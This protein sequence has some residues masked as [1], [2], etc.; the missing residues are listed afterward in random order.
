MAVLL[1]MKLTDKLM[2]IEILGR[3]VA[4]GGLDV[5]GD[6]FHEVGRV[7]VLDV[8]HLLVDLLGGQ[9]TTEHGG[10]G[11]VAAVAGVGGTHHV[12]GVE[13]LLRQ[14]GHS[15]STVLLRTTRSQGGKANHVEV[16][17][18]EGDQ[19]DGELAQIGVELTGEAEGASDTAHD[20]RHE[21][22]EISECGGGELQSAEADVVRAK[23]RRQNAC[24]RNGSVENLRRSRR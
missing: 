17:T 19:V 9:A 10:G 7:L 13:H 16:E 24:V 20:G 22:A 23:R 1:P 12:L 18:G 14:L 15:Q 21:M 11:E 3:D 6:P 4:N 5:V 2:Y 8:E